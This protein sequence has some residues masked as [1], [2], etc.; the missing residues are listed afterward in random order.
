MPSVSAT[1]S[2]FINVL[3]VIDSPPSGKKCESSCFKSE[4][5][6]RFSRT[7]FL[8]PCRQERFLAH[9]CLAAKQEVLAEYYIRTVIQ[10]FIKQFCLVSEPY[11]TN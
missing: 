8:P 3:L 10:F 11:Y 5:R 6:C 4:I 2:T 9:S 1:S 7:V